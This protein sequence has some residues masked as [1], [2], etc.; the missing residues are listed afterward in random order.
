LY[1]YRWPDE[2]AW[3]PAE[4]RHEAAV[5]EGDTAE[6]RTDWGNCSGNVYSEETK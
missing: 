1:G 5:I 4:L 3:S 2:Q 6:G